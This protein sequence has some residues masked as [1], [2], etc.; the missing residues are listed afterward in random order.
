LSL[1]AY[2]IVRRTLLRLLLVVAGIVIVVGADAQTAPPRPR[3]GYL[4]L[5]SEDS[6]QAAFRA[7]FLSGMKDLGYVGSR[8]AVMAY[9]FAEGNSARLPVLALALVQSG[10]DV[11]VGE[12][13]QA[14]FAL[15]G[16]TSSAPVVTLSCDAVTS[17]LVAQL[18]RPGGNVTGISCLTPELTVK[19]MQLVRE[20]DP[21][22]K[23]VGILWNSHDPTKVK[24]VDLARDAASSMGLVHSS[25]EVRTAEDIDARFAAMRADGIEG[26]L[27]VGDSFMILHSQRIVASV[28]QLR[29]PAVYPFREFADA[30]GLLCYGP[31]LPAMFYSM[32]GYVDRILKGAKPGDLPVEQ[33]TTFDFMINLSAARSIG[34][35]IPQSLLAQASKTID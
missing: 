18:A 30:G 4:S 5:A 16:A 22:A 6:P 28:A 17:G 14:S 27:L 11:L 34:I 31:S 20:L 8:A 2:P 24:E 29:I 25:Y 7:A 23:R 21:K 12:G 32:A 35:A 13:Q 1:S 15:K 26:L 9:K 3:I 33:P 10:V 19:R